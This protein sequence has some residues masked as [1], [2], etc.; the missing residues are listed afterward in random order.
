MSGNFYPKEIMTP[1][2]IKK[3]IDVFEEEM[4]GLVVEIFDEKISSGF[5]YL[6][7]T[8]DVFVNFAEY[9]KEKYPKIL[10]YNPK[11]FD[12]KVPSIDE[13]LSELADVSE[14]IDSI[15]YH[16]NIKKESLLNKQEKKR[17]KVGSFLEGKILI[18]TE[19]PLPNALEEKKESTLFSD[20]ENKIREIKYNEVPKKTVFNKYKD[21][22]KLSDID[23]Y[24]AR[25]T[26]PVSLNKWK[27]SLLEIE[28]SDGRK[29][30]VY[31]E[32][33][34]EGSFNNFELKINET[35]EKNKQTTM[36]FD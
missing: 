17:I 33:H 3:L 13:L 25:I 6:Y 19:N 18:D 16:L 34:R 1:K 31:L 28:I 5:A 10:E 4:N 22:Q 9:I 15:L 21:T 36:K 20:L 32:N 8:Y 29:L 26:V 12:G 14:V 24:I 27:T 11:I 7:G 23:R 30:E 2:A 35:K